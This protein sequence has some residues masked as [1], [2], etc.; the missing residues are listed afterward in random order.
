MS[1]LCLSSSRPRGVECPRPSSRST[2][3]E[4]WR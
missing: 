2:V 3:F 4:S 1:P